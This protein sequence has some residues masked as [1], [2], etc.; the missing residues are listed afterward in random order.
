MLGLTTLVLDALGIGAGPV[1]GTPF[2]LE[3]VPG[4][5]TALV[6][7][8]GSGKSTVASLVARFW[9]PDTGAVRLDGTDIRDLPEAGYRE[10]L[11]TVLQDARLIRGTLRENLVLG[12]PDASDAELADA[13]DA[14]HLDEVIAGLPKGLDTPLD[15]DSLSGG[16]RQRVA[17]ARALLGDARIVVL[18]E[19]TAAADPDS[20]WAVKR[21][22]DRL[23][24][25]RTV[26]AIS[27]RLH[28]VAGAD[29][30]V[31]MDGGRV[32]ESGTHAS[33]LDRDG[34]YARMTREARAGTAPDRSPD[35][36]P[37]PTDSPDPEAP[38]R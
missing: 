28:T 20:E 27:H 22:L 7:P 14:A 13:I 29:R 33:L 17:I 4:G 26:L 12:R 36:S 2:G 1:P 19:A 9:D 11:A 31:V 34:L 3:L 5:V 15:R 32:V 25:S 24:E 35:R 38:T 6:G 18:D 21:G 8:S 30:I 10:Q 16:Q 37:H 23:L